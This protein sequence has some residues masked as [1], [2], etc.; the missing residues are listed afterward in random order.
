[1]EKLKFLILPG[2]E[3]RSLGH[4][5]LSPESDPRNMD[6]LTLDKLSNGGYSEEFSYSTQT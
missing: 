1:M 5:A 4:P 6:F 3:I 2:L